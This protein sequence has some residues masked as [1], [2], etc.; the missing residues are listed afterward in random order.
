LFGL[1]QAGEHPD[2]HGADHCGR[3]LDHGACAFGGE[4]ASP[5]GGSKAVAD[6][7]DLRSLCTPLAILWALCL[8]VAIWRLPDTDAA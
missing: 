2:R 5:G 8:A 1:A 7:G 6:A 3:L 4:T